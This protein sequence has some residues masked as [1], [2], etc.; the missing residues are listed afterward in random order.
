MLRDLVGFALIA[1][2]FTLWVMHGVILLTG[3]Y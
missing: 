2:P 1:V 3:G